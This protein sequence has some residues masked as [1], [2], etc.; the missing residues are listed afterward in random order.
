MRR[1]QIRAARRLLAPAALAGLFALAAAG[2]GAAHEGATGVV[3]ERM[4]LMEAMGK[5]LKEIKERVERNRDPDG[6]QSRALAIHDA[7]PGIPGLFPLG[8]QQA[9]SEAKPDIWQNREG[10][11]ARL[12]DLAQTSQALVDA[13]GAGDPKQIGLRFTAMVRSCG[14][15]H[16]EFRARK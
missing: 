11:Q 1:I 5:R 15:C 6:I 14:G 7:V 12:Q 3:K 9:L 10:F 13:A 8:G 4:D 2:S 16:D